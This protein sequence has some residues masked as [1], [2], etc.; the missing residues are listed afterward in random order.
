[1]VAGQLVIFIRK[2]LFLKKKQMKTLESRK[3]DVIKLVME[4]QNEEV[5]SKFEDEAIKIKDNYNFKP[6]I[7]DAIKPVRKNVSLEQL[8]KEQNYQPVSY[9]EFR[10]LADKIEIE[11]PIEELL[12]T[13]TK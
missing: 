12:A 8:K 4:V 13:L 6:D 1:M 5:L 9:Q 7:A 10:Q 3:L 2:A 11:E